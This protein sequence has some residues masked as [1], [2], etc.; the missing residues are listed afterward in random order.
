MRANRGIGS[1]DAAVP[2]EEYALGALAGL[3]DELIDERELD[4]PVLAGHSWGGAVAMAYAATHPDDVRA[5]ILL[6]SGHL[7]YADVE[8][9]DTLHLPDNA[10]GRAMRGLLEPVSR[11]GRWSPE[12]DPDAP[13]PRDGAAAR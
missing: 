1:R 7:D 8:D 6:D 9:V 13:L 5:L 10:Q 4:R 12:R 11:T 2:A 3:L